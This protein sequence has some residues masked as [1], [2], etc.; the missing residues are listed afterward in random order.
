MVL[1]VFIRRNFGLAAAAFAALALLGLDTGAALAQSASC[2]QLNATLQSLDSNGDFRNADRGNSD[3]RSLQANERGAE[4]AYIRTGCQ[5]DQQQGY[6]Q[7]PQCRGLA[8]QILSQRAQIAQLT[9]SLGNADA[10][11]QRREQVL[12]D[13]ARFGCNQQDSQA[14]FSNDGGGSYQAPRRRNFLEQLFG[15]RQSV[16]DTGYGDPSQYDGGDQIQDPYADM[17]STQDTIRTVCVRLSDGYYWPVSYATTRDYITQDA[18]TCQAAC[19]DQSVD[20][21]YY[22][23]PGQEPEQMINTIGQPYTSLP[24]AFAYRKSFDIANTCKPQQTLGQVA[25]DDLGDGRLRAMI[26]YGGD[27]FPLPLRD[28]RSAEVAIQMASAPSLDIPLPRPRPDAAETTPAV[29]PTAAPVVS[30]ADRIVKVGNK[31]VRV[32]GPDTPYAPPTM[33]AD[34]SG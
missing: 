12:Q 10:V 1:P 2:A 13:I 34:T 8:K 33:P 17:Q 5:R 18:Q 26:S 11:S 31:I 6:P 23:N 32:V 27:T 29:V 25:M 28:P 20:L 14:R 30:A 9:Q 4:S 19:P 7:T 21:Y 15:G 16:D 3:L 24:T 22:N